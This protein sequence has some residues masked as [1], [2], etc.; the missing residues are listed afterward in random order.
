MWRFNSDINKWE[1][2]NGE[3]L[4][5][6]FK[7]YQQEYNS[8]RF[9]SKCLSGSTYVP[10][11]STENIFDILT[12]NKPRNWY[13][14]SNFSQYSITNIPNQHATP[15]D[16]NNY[17][18]YYLK[19]N[20][21]YGL[22]LKNL[23][24]PEDVISNSIN[25]YKYV[26]LAT[27]DSIED[28]SIDF[29]DFK[30]D[31]IRVREGHRILI[32]DQKSRIFLS[33]TIN[34]DDY[35][36]G[37]WRIVDEIGTDI[38]YEYFNS[39]NGI[40]NFTNNKL[41]REND[42]EDYKN[43][44]R[45]RV[46]V[47]LGE[48]NAGKQFHLMRL[49][50][51]YFPQPSNGDSVYYSLKENWILRN[52]VDYNNILDI[53]YYDVLT[54]NEI[55]YSD[56]DIDYL[57]PKRKIFI[58]EFGVIINN[59][60]GVSNVIRNKYKVNL[61]SISQTTKYYWIVGDKGTL[62]KVRK[63][64]FNIEKIN[65]DCKC[66]VN[67]IVN[68]NLTSISFFND[69]NGVL[70]GNLNIILY[71]SDG[72][73]N[74]KRID[75][76]AFNAFNYNKVLYKNINN[77]YIVG[78]NGV[79]LN[80]K[81]ESNEWKAYK[82]RISKFIDDEDEFLLV[83]NIN[84]IISIELDNW[85]IGYAFYNT[86]TI[87]DQKDLLFL[88]TDNNNIII[89]DILDSIPFHTDFM[90]LEFL[91]KDYSDI[92]RITYEPG[93]KIFYFTGFDKSTNE[94]GIFSFELDNFT[95]IGVGNSFSNRIVS[96]ISADFKSDFNPNKILNDP[97]ELIIAGDNSMMLSAPYDVDLIFQ[98]IDV[99][100]SDKLK[101]RLLFLDY[102]VASKLNFF[103][104]D[105]DYRLPNS[106]EFDWNGLDNFEFKMIENSPQ[107]PS[108]LTQSQIN[109]WEYWKDSNSTFE[110]YSSTGLMDDNNRVR[111]SSK[112]RKAQNNE[113]QTSS[114]T[115]NLDDIINLSPNL[116]NN[117]M[118]RFFG[119]GITPISPPTSIFDVYLYD[120][121]MIIKY[122]STFDLEVGDVLRI[123][124]DVVNTNLLVNKKI[125]LGSENWAYMY[126]EFNEN[127]IKSILNSGNIKIKN[128]NTYLDELNLIDNFNIHPISNGYE[129]IYNEESEILTVNPKFNNLTS[130]Y[131][132]STKIE[133][134]LDT[135]LMEYENSFI[136]F[137]YTPNYNILDYLEYLNDSLINPTFFANKEYLAMPNY[138]GIPITDGTSALFNECY[139]DSNKIENKLIFG[140]GLK[141]EWES[142]FLNTFIDLK[143][144]N[145]IEKLE[146]NKLLVINKY[147]DS[148]NDYYVIEFHKKINYSIG[149]QFSSLDIISRRTL[150]QISNDLQS[151]NNIQR[152]YWN[153]EYRGGTTQSGMTWDVSYET[154]EPE[155][156]FKINTDSYAKIL[157]SDYDTI[158]YTSGLVYT[159]ANGQISLNLTKLESEIKTNIVNT[160][161]YSGNLYIICE[162]KHNL[163]TG[164][165]IVLYF[166]G[167]NGSSQELN[168]QYFGYH[169]A[170]YVNDYAFY[171][172]VEW[173]TATSVGNDVGYFTYIK[174][175]SFLNYQPIDIINVGIDGS[176]KNSIEL[177]PSNTR[178]VGD[179]YSL[180]NI[181]WNKRRFRLVDN[182]DVAHLSRRFS[183]IFEA[184]ISEAIIG[185][186]SN[187]IIWYTGTWECGRW[188]E[189]TWISGVWIS[190]D[191][192]GGTWKS[193]FIRDNYSNVEID[194]NR[195]SDPNQSIWYDGRW[196]G[197]QWE[198]GT[199][200]SGR[201]YGGDW[202]GGTWRDGIWNDGNWHDGHFNG[203]VW[204][205]GNWY[206]GIFNT[207]NA[208]SYWLDGTWKS[209]DFENGMWF[210][211]FFGSKEGESRFGT[212][213]YNSR[214]AIWK[215]GNW[216]N[217]SFHS[218]LNLD[219]SGNYKVSDIHKHSIWYTGN[220]YN[221]EFY[222]G[223]VY[224]IDFKSGIWHGGILEDISIV[225][226]TDI[227]NGNYLSI[228]GNNEFNIGY[229]ISIIDN[230]MGGSYSEL[231][232]NDNPGIYTVLYS[233]EDIENNLTYIYIDKELN[234]NV[235]GEET[236]LRLVSRFRNCNW[237]SGIWTNG[238]YQN[239]LWEG[240]IWYNGIFEATWT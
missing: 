76:E 53:N 189:G 88:V 205:F 157:L 181:D 165:G 21:E 52:R 8:Y 6:D 23:F 32:K 177:V 97:T 38:E 125:T 130:Y 214:A 139:L 4:I 84:D 163:N 83:D 69:L 135:Y 108:Y 201:W 110:H 70:V 145:G 74:W 120:Y 129:M 151:L 124:S 230:Q 118:S 73:L 225:G 103:T 116:E 91:N 166:T 102:D 107:A 101:S 238:I 199:W 16:N 178:L 187:S 49:N 61:K 86:Q 18:D 66:S 44:I 11:N 222:G 160:D 142:I 153:K 2:N 211:G 64:D 221:G 184:E 75:I 14:S 117:T 169:I 62:L 209:G 143:L 104:D 126:T 159:D 77:F 233:I 22:T 206:N 19:Y 131:N 25:N 114:I 170:N 162:D 152:G 167:G 234:F 237:K 137:G 26:D 122:D 46:F 93:T 179:Q 119:Y 13:I 1:F 148:V 212:R 161:N 149:D 7:F 63:H 197:G 183:W 36:D 68:S 232:N 90:Y 20:S 79:F 239:G 173:G 223:V 100:F 140:V 56:G 65:I 47:K 164:D 115:N 112:F 29:L 220:W 67:K 235:S 172:D 87:N 40:Y 180:I 113:F 208:P 41:I 176:G 98:D 123:E 216:I 35:F 175:D 147:Y 72:G 80:F 37:Y 210:N 57:I 60:S 95:E 51:G 43:S 146:L 186:D 55:S 229:E 188:F 71:T 85:D 203:G 78:N 9:Y 34:P 156:N 31:N 218:R 195:Y 89:H 127:I 217:G 92:S 204:V 58:G 134:N 33:N 202:L 132:L 141:L 50:S 192:Y 138:V 154:L 158:R 105:G 168:N 185:Q 128:L 82:R 111:Y 133:T 174:G 207:S 144:D 24:T 54:H 42:L 231:G 150:L 94:V 219:D 136:K 99:N 227:T 48:V 106:V 45:Y 121:L 182:L 191:W 59:Q 236:N 27:T 224:N 200:I 155:F 15:I 96:E 39:E 194:Q 228:P 193:K 109:W 190:G 3:I 213:A 240:G 226:I 81:R 215:S 196:F 171:V 5:D 198:M 10:I 17:L 12:Y 30:I 28:I